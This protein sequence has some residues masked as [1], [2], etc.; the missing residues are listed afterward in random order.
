[1]G[2]HAKETQGAHIY[3]YIYIYIYIVRDGSPRQRDS[4]SP[5]IVATPYHPIVSGNQQMSL[6]IMCACPMMF[7][8][9]IVWRVL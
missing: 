5:L 3:M 1:M 4:G 9:C 6:L 7:I 8:A 2:V